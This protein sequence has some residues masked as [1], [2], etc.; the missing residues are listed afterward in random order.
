[1]VTGTDLTVTP[2]ITT[3]YQLFDLV[4]LH[5]D[6]RA[7]GVVVKVSKDNLT[8]LDTTGKVVV[9][10]VK[11][12]KSK[13]NDRHLRAV[14]KSRRP[15]SPGDTIRVV[16]GPHCNRQGVVKHLADNFVFFQ[17]LSPQP[18]QKDRRG[19]TEA[20]R[21]PSRAYCRMSLKISLHSLFLFILGSGRDEQLWHPWC[22]STIGDGTGQSTSERRKR[23]VRIVWRH[24]TQ[25]RIWCE[26]TFASF[27]GTKEWRWV[28]E[29]RIRPREG[30]NRTKR[31]ENQ[32][33]T[34]QRIRWQSSG[35]IQR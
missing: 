20:A 35:C 6:P 32:V 21:S 2:E 11:E 7:R 30:S 16:D 15:I 23:T 13:V 18:E 34:V 8:L 26:R 17:V 24:R 9:K 22:A 19:N 1:M 10:P 14:D 27:Y 12:I 28:W 3:L 4:S 25:W 31:G 29:R 33:W 5:S